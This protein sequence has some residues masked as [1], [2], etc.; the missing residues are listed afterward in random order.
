MTSLPIRMAAVRKPKGLTDLPLEMLWKISENLSSADIACLA[1]TNRQLLSSFVD[2]AFENFQSYRTPPDRDTSPDHHCFDEIRLNPQSR[3]PVNR[4]RDNARVDLLSRISRDQPNYYLCFDCLQ[5]HFWKRVERLTWENVKFT[6]DTHGLSPLDLRLQQPLA[7]S[8]YP[9]DSLHELHFAHLQLVMRRFYHGPEAERSR[10]F[11]HLT[12]NKSEGKTGKDL[13]MTLFS[14]EGRICTTPPSLYIRTQGI[15]VVPRKYLERYFIQMRWWDCDIAQFYVCM[16]VPTQSSKFEEHF[17]SLIRRH[18]SAPHPYVADKGTCDACKKSWLFEIR[19]MEETNV[20]L[21]LT[22][23]TDLGPGLATND[24]HWDS[25]LCGWTEEAAAQHR[26]VDPRKRFERHS[27][28]P[29]SPNALCVDQI[30][31]RNIRLLK[32]ERHREESSRSLTDYGRPGVYMLHGDPSKNPRHSRR[33][34]A[35]H[36]DE[37]SDSRKKASLQE[38]PYLDLSKL[39]RFE[40]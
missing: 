6:H 5:L 9:T 38:D 26:M 34:F 3:P 15:A 27:V 12:E 29:E 35:T 20:S 37:I 18:C 33:I 24:T 2:T 11:L 1:L 40:M 7:I 17:E 21:T 39:R 32:E 8:H 22:V 28:Q 13:K 16:D 25:H 4:S 23:W 10:L 30:Y 14:V 36:T 31:C 19:P